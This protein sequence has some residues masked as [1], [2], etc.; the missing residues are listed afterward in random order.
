[1]W[2]RHAALALNGTAGDQA[3]GRGPRPTP[4][5]SRRQP[6]DPCNKVVGSYNFFGYMKPKA[7]IRRTGLFVRVFR[8]A[9]CQGIKYSFRLVRRNRDAL[10]M[11][12]QCNV[13]RV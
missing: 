4:P 9:T 11:H 5:S 3:S 6:A 10:I 1:M 2:R 8:S 7:E 13:L 12:G